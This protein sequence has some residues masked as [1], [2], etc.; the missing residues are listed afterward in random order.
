MS[1]WIVE[2]YNQ[3]VTFYE[4]CWLVGILGVKVKEDIV[5]CFFLPKQWPSGG[6]G[7]QPT[8]WPL[9]NVIG[10]RL[11]TSLKDFGSNF[12]DHMT[13]SD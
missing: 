9:Y 8:Q 5:A 1:L 13:F 4:V 7:R 12:L 3:L 6:P 10:K 11:C 2:A